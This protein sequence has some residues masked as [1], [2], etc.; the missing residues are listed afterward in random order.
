MSSVRPWLVLAVLFLSTAPHAGE[1]PPPDQLTVEGVGLRRAAQAGRTHLL[2]SL[3][4]YTIS[5]YSNGPIERERLGAADVAKA[6][7]IDVTCTDDARLRVGFDWRRELV[8]R[9]ES[10]AMAHLLG[11]FA[12]LRHGDVVQIEFVPTKG[13]T[14]R[15]NKAVA[16]SGGHHDLMLAFLD[17]WLGERP[18]SDEIKRTL[19]ASSS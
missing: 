1:L 6:L 8:P 15:V 7:R 2:G 4:L 18:V 16:V 10:R 3:N 9:L 17:H 11:S 19:L 5:L 12:P 14:V 13:T